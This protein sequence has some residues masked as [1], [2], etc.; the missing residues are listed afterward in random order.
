MAQPFFANEGRLKVQLFRHDRLLSVLL[1]NAQVPLAIAKIGA[2]LINL[3]FPHIDEI[4]RIL[5]VFDICISSTF[6]IDT[7]SFIFIL[8]FF[9]Y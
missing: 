5:D 2:V 9:L 3:W 4:H 7:H 8:F 1:L 6:V